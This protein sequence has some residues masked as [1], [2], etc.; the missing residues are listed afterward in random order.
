M[1]V[2]ADHQAPRSL[3]SSVELLCIPFLDTD[4]RKDT[5]HAN[6]VLLSRGY[7]LWFIRLLRRV[8]AVGLWTQVFTWEECSLGIGDVLFG[9]GLLLI[10][11]GLLTIWLKVGLWLACVGILFVALAFWYWR[12]GRLAYEKFS[13]ELQK[14]DK[15]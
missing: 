1:Q 13:R 15:P 11:I 2:E 5:E 3:L 12:R 9:Y 14:Q 7:P 10:F 8:F 4:T 6:A